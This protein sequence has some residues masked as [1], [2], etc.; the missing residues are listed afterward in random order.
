MRIGIDAT[1]IGGGGGIT[2]L[3]EIL[4]HYNEQKFKNI[5]SSITVFASQKVLDKIDDFDKLNKITFPELNKGLFQRVLFQIT[6][7]D[8]H[9]RLRCDILLSL[10]GDYVGKFKPLVGMSRNMLLYDRKLWK[11]IKEFKEILR[12]W[13]NFQKQKRSFNNATGIVFIS[14]YAKAYIT[15]TLRLDNKLIQVIHHGVATKFTGDLKTHK[16][17][18]EFSI[19]NPFKFIYISTVHVYKHQWNVVKAIGNLRALGY[20]VELHL[21]GGVIFSKAGAKLSKAIDEVDSEGKFIINHGHVDY[22]EI[23]HCY[24]YANGIIFAS[25]CENMPNTLIESMASGIPI[26]CS[27]KQPMPEFLKQNGYYFDSY[28]VDSIQASIENLILN[29]NDNDKLVSGSLTEVKKYDW[30]QTSEKTFDFLIDVYKF[31][32]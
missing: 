13:I 3:R 30:K 19:E 2:H 7:Y 8:S 27:D 15:K 24:K 20:P 31:N 1:N 28:D 25:T 14:N 4:L 9:I 5:I 18:S 12:F 17:I 11:E 6:K 10:T 32:K 22:E 23:E 21:V 26:A 29:T 16:S